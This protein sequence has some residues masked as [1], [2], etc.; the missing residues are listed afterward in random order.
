MTSRLLLVGLLATAL[1]SACGSTPPTGP[2]P[3][4][5]PPT[6]PEPPPPPPPPKTL[7][8]TKILSFGDSMTYGT[9]SGAIAG[10]LTPGLPESYPFKLQTLLTARYSTQTITVANGG[11]AGKQAIDDRERFDGVFREAQPQLVIILEGA[12]DLNALNGTGNGDVSP[13]SGAVEDMVRNALAKGAQVFVSTLPPQRCCTSKTAEPRLRD[14]YNNDLRTMASKKG[15]VLIDLDSLL[16]LSYIGQDGLH[17]T[18]EGYQKIAEIFLDAIKS[19]F[20][21]TGSS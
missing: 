19:R 4:T 16:P 10:L 2:G 3:V 13:I 1:T 5:P 12:N 14:K 17:P 6:N 7:S 18:E 21:V 11:Y 8:I 20:E 9:T 15:A